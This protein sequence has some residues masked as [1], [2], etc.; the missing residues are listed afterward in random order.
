MTIVEYI[1]GPITHRYLMKKTK[2]ELCHLHNEYSRALGER[3]SMLP[4]YFNREGPSREQ[5]ASSIMALIRKLP[6]TD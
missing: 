2:P 5:L 4:I 1:G 3:T 6:N